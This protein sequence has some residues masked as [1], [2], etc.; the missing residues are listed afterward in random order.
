MRASFIITTRD[1]PPQTLNATLAGLARTAAHVR[2]EVIVVD[3]GSRAPV[4]A[5][6]DGVTLL[7]SA[8]PR[9]VSPSRR[10]GAAAARGEILVWLDAHMSFADDWLD[11]ML[12]H[13][14]SGALVCSAFCDYD[15]ATSHCWG[16]DY[17]WCGE[18][19]YWH[20]RYPGFGLRHRVA[21]PAAD[22]V[23]VPMII[24]ACYALSQPAYRRLGGF[25]PLFRAW[26]VDEQDICLRAHLL[27][28]PVRCVTAARVGHLSRN[29]FPYPVC[30]EHLEYNQLVMIRSVFEEQTVARLER[31][32]A[33]IPHAVDVWL[34]E[35][36]LE[37]WRTELQSRRVCPDEE[38]L[39]GLALVLPE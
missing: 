27:G 12:Q 10:I 11:P 15:L 8:E 22:V 26:G 38:L 13:A 7:R 36:D 6:P 28:I 20:Q 23:D 1:E 2:H 33:P 4:A 25:S 5:L 35:I 34:D 32:F 3:D 19:D 30:F 21:P 18:R 14:R 37:P 17:F 39:R 29:A 16:A 24:G 9:G 31:Y